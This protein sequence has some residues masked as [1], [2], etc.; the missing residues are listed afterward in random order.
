[1]GQP[2]FGAP[3]V[4]GSPIGKPW[5]IG[6]D[7]ITRILMRPSRALRWGAVALALAV[8]LG[9]DVRANAQEFPRLPFLWARFKPGS[10]K[11]VRR[12]T[13]TISPEDETTA[14]STTDTR[15][16]LESVDAQSVTLRME[17][18]MELGGK[19]LAGT[20][21]EVTEGLHGQTVEG[22]VRVEPLGSDTLTIEGRP[23]RCRVEQVKIT[24]ADATTLAKTWYCDYVSPS[25]LRSESTTT[26]NGS[27]ELVHRRSV[28]VTG[29]VPRRRILARWRQAVS[30]RVVEQHRSGTTVATAV[31]C[32][33]V[34][35]GIVDEES[36]E[37][38]SEGRLVRRSKIEL[39]DYSAE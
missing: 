32:P 19:T 17:A 7:R 31:N 22:E 39:V 5:L 21:Q 23:Y 33:E 25:L 24:A 18:V 12:V 30:I 16:T 11:L 3:D 35:G 34:P 38:D 14:T 15:T 27:G 36:H 9:G 26:E 28:Q 8:I 4:A 10:W 29:F 13:E 1:M 2:G 6:M 37:Y 20:P